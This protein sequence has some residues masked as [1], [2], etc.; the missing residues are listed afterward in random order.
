MLSNYIKIAW[1]N[2]LR[3]R[4]YSVINIFGLAI[5]LACFMFIALY[6]QDE[7]SYDKFHDN[8]ENIYRVALDRQYPGRLRQYAIIPHSYSE[9]IDKDFAEVEETTRLFFFNGNN[10]IVR[11][12]EQLYE[13]ENIMF[14]DSNF[15]NFFSIPV[16][17]G[18]PTTCLVDPAGVVLT[19][20][21]AQKF[22]GSVNVVG[23]EIDLPQNDNNLKVTA[24]CADVPVNSHLKFDLLQSSNSIGFIQQPNFVN[25]SAYT[26]LRVHPEADIA[27]LEGKFP[28]LVTKYISGQ[29]LQ[30]FGIEY[31]EYQAQ[32]NGYNYYLQPLE[33]IY[34]DSNLEAEIKTPGSRQRIR[35]FTL[36]AILIIGIA[37]INFMNLS[38]ARSA[39]RAR[40]VGIRKTL[41][42]DRSQLSAQFLTE[43][44]IISLIAGL[45]AWGLNVIALDKFNSLTGKEFLSSQFLSVPYL[46]LLV[47]AS[48]L[49]GILSGLY[50]A[51]ALSSFQPVQVL[52]GQLM[53]NS[54]GAGLRNALVVF[55]F[56]ISVFLIIS[57][58]MI[59]RQWVFTQNKSLGFDKESVVNLQGAGGLTPQQSETFKN[60]LRNLPGVMA[61]GGCN[62]RPGGQYFGLSFRQNGQNEVTAGSGV[63]VDEGYIECMAMEVTQ[64]RSFS[65]DFMDTLS[66]IINE[67][68]VKEMG[69]DNPIGAQLVSNDQFLNPVE[70]EPSIYTVV[71]VV[72]DFHFQSLHHVISPLYFIHN[73]RNFIPGVDNIITLKLQAAAT[74]R[75][76]GEIEQIWNRLQPDVPF[77]YAFLDQDWAR[78]YEK[79]MTTRRVSGLFSLIAIFIACLGL[80]ALAA[81]TAERKTKELA[82][83][84]FLVHRCQ[85]LWVC[86]PRTF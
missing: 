77:R 65:E 32:G 11:I 38:T 55:Q 52:R 7:L 84:R 69:L 40:E 71:G 15:F 57:T 3:N 12:G 44:V 4:S 37:A 67:A 29:M 13:E 61:V 26:Y 58:I 81:F 79:E 50:P 28:D 48:V 34:L 51:L 10:L 6:V 25:F 66:I 39:G 8:G 73:Q 33:D 74:T 18:D 14:A 80:L 49:T 64:G 1:R 60:Q 30:R 45:L 27:A 2:L 75:A 54:K 16:I 82:F 9:V 19:E 68:A 23:R 20:S 83:A 62:T 56:A 35:F 76:L 72:Q 78:L 24:V 22:F 63:I 85:A 41:G 46:G 47:L 86:Y 36:I 42:S 17:H 43:A 70:G 5:G 59:Y 21:T 53:S 31:S